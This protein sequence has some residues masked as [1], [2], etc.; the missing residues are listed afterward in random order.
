MALESRIRPRQFWFTVGYA[1]LCAVLGLWGAYDYWERI[2]RQEREFVEYQ[3][4]LETV[5]RFAEMSSRGGM[6]FTPE[7]DAEYRAAQ[8]V[9]DRFASGAPTPVAAYDRPLQ[10]WVYMIGCGILGTGWCAVS[11]VRTAPRAYTLDDDGT[12]HAHGRR[13]APDEVTGIDM[14]RWMAKSIATLQ[15]RNGPPVVLDD[16]KF[17]GMHLIVGRFAHQF[18]PER[19]NTD[20]T[21]V[22]RSAAGAP[23]GESAGAADSAP[24]GAGRG[25]GSPQAPSA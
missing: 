20:G 21:L 14:S 15:V 25:P 1:A 23:D 6:Q 9:V 5:N 10:L 22:K 4:A 3:Q 8:A 12:L 24:E 19:W 17:S 2:P 7:Q 18:E 13:I 11:L 16:Y